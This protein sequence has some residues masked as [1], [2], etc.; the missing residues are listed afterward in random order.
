[1]TSYAN[2]QSAA[3]RIAL[4]DGIVAAVSDVGG[5]ESARVLSAP[6]AAGSVF[7]FYNQGH[8]VIMPAADLRAA[9]THGFAAYDTAVL[10]QHACGL[11]A[12][13]ASAALTAA[14]AHGSD[15]T[16]GR[17]TLKTLDNQGDPAPGM[18]LLVN[19]DDNTAANLALASDGDG[20]AKIE[21]PDGHYG[22]LYATVNGDETDYVVD[23]DVTVKDGTAVTLDPRTATESLPTPATPKP[24]DL[25]SSSLFLAR[26]S[27]DGYGQYYGYW[28]QELNYNSTPLDVRFSPTGKATHGH[29]AILPQFD[30]SSPAGTANPYTYHIAEPV[31]AIPATFATKVDPAGLATVTR[32]FGAAGTP[33]EDLMS[34]AALPAWDAH[35]EVFP[36]SGVSFASSGA[37]RTEYFSAGKQ[38][39]WQTIT[40]DL[41]GYSDMSVAP[42]TTYRAGTHTTE[43][44]NTGGLHPGVTL[45]AG[46]GVVC[47]ACSDDH[48]LQF[49]IL[50]LGDNTPGHPALSTATLAAG[51]S[52]T[53]SF[54][55]SRD[56]TVL[57]SAD[58]APS[59]VSITVPAGKATYRL[60]DDVTRNVAAIPLST[61]SHTVWTF[62]A[63]PG[64]GG[65]V[66]GSWFCVNGDTTCD[67][68]PLLFAYYNT[69]A[70][71][72]NQ[73]TP[74][75]HTLDLTVQH[76]QHAVAP[77]VSGASVSVSY[78]DG[79]TWQAATTKGGDG[80][81]KA[82][83][84]VP[85]SASGHDVSL[86]V[87]AWDGAGNRIDQTVI[88]AYQ[89][90]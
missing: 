6:R 5:A 75:R 28:L 89:V 76:Q 33:G 47:P 12:P 32:N 25:T 10:A 80:A 1:M 16:L 27:G 41:G 82:A 42:A 17:L 63:D 84:T 86:R 68:L 87:S 29:L 20:I 57:G 66:P 38:L 54:S 21:V 53:N 7:S 3:C 72:L 62:V 37:S 15:Y 19:A 31:D 64:H 13:T 43:N 55:V 88:R 18:V 23:A 51:D 11:A 67:A 8:M 83:F 60:T 90:Q 79:A 45:D 59:L 77:E 44:F 26:G 70:N 56:G 4:P 71:L 52:E 35:T 81:F 46:A 30:F 24:A 50:P 69:D 78:D 48:S 9:A 74:G 58:E 85:A 49:N 14:Q 34:A 65:V 36:L 39:T 2:P 61:A 73:V 22:M 40:Q